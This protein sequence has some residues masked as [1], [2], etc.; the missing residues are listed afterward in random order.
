MKFDAFERMHVCCSSKD[1]ATTKCIYAMMPMT[2]FCLVPVMTKRVFG[3]PTLM[4]TQI[5]QLG[6]SPI[7]SLPYHQVAS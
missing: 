6:V 5:R 2:I 7:T 4:L 3:R 1:E